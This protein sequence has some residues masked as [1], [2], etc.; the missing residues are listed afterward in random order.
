MNERLSCTSL[1]TATI[2]VEHWRM[3]LTYKSSINTKGEYEFDTLNRCS[4]PSSSSIKSMF[5]IHLMDV[6]GLVC[7]T[8]RNNKNDL[9]AHAS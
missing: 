9:A 3:M 8:F 1:A 7:L 5:S 6:R 4:C 2:G